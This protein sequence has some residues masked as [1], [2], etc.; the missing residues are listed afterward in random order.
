ME[1]NIK[2]DI[3]G[4]KCV[5]MDLIFRLSNIKFQFEEYCEHEDIRY[6][7][8]QSNFLTT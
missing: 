7:V 1:D 3:T 5:V 2:V 4:T 8:I 6:Y